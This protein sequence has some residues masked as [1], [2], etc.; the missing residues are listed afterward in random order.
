[1]RFIGKLSIG[2][3]AVTLGLGFLGAI[4]SVNEAKWDA[5]VKI[6]EINARKE[7]QEKKDKK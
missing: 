2:L 6:A 3:G 7:N 4:K 1:M 5:K